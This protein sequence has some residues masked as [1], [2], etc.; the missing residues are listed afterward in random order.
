[1]QNNSVPSSVVACLHSPPNPVAASLHLRR[2]RA[3][4]TQVRKVV[5]S[6]NND[7]ASTEDTLLHM[8][9]ILTLRH[10]EM[11]SELWEPEFKV[12]DLEETCARAEE[13]CATSQPVRFL[14]GP[15]ITRPS[16]MSSI[17]RLPPLLTPPP[18]SLASRSP[19]PFN[20]PCSPHASALA[21]RH[22]HRHDVK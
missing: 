9:T 3:V 21:S 10:S 12:L 13:G 1:M 4:V 5:S 20:F 19:L 7:T 6:A 17:Q 15:H 22:V 8:G 2:V 14:T 18:P 16:S 11:F